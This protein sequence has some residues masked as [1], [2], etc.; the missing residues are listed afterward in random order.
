MVAFIFGIL[1]HGMG[2]CI[3]KLLSLYVWPRR[4]LRCGI[5]VQYWLETLTFLT[6]AAFITSFS[7]PGQNGQHFTQDITN[8]ILMII[9][10]T[11]LS[12]FAFHESM[13][14]V[15]NNTSA[16]V[17]GMVWG[18]SNA[19]SAHWR[20]YATIGEMNWWRHLL[21]S[22]FKRLVTQFFEQLGIDTT[23]LAVQK[24]NGA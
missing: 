22:Y 9:F 17:Q 4:I 21:S 19:D 18:R 24:S 20:I 8:C 2:M 23:S 11:S 15:P 16:W 14:P 5:T 10:F 1:E 6:I 12:R 3:L 13:F 7:P